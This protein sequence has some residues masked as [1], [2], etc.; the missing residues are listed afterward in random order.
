M[1]PLC[2]DPKEKFLSVTFRVVFSYYDLYSVIIPI[3]RNPGILTTLELCLC[4]C[5]VLVV[6]PACSRFCF[7]M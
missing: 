6:Q 1:L 4:V 5:G 3:N 7:S 2:V